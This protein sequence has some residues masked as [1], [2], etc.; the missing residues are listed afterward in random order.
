MALKCKCEG[1]EGIPEKRRAKKRPRKTTTALRDNSPSA[2]HREAASSSQPAAPPPAPR[3]PAAPANLVTTTSAAPGTSAT[4]AAPAAT[5]ASATLA[6]KSDISFERTWART[7]E[8]EANLDSKRPLRTAMFREMQQLRRTMHRY[9]EGR[10]DR[11]RQ[12]Q[13]RTQ[14]LSLAYFARLQKEADQEYGSDESDER[15]LEEVP[16]SGSEYDPSE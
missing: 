12:E 1:A 13:Q 2:H 16:P 5:E 3:Q 15:E 7:P 14:E 6:R 11:I 8:D 10:V 9:M 4:L